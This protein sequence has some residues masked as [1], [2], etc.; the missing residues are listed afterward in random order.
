M[1]HDDSTIQHALI[2]IGQPVNPIRVMSSEAISKIYAG[3]G[4]GDPPAGLDA[5]RAP[6]DRADPNIY[7][8]EDSLAYRNAMSNPSAVG[9][10]KLAAILLHEQVHNTDGEF[11]AYSLQSDFVRSKLNGLPSRHR[12]EATRYLQQLD[13]TVRALSRAERRRRDFSASQLDQT[14]AATVLCG[15]R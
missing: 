3:A 8:N 9:R 11:A 7:V 15:R 5:F 2:V 13:A 1:Q 6:H 12:Q 14:P 10:L 4:V